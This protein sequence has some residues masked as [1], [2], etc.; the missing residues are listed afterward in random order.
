MGSPCLESSI[1]GTVDRGARSERVEAV[2]WKAARRMFPGCGGD[3][4]T[5][6][7]EDVGTGVGSICFPWI[8][9]KGDAACVGRFKG[10]GRTG[11]EDSGSKAGSKDGAGAGRFSPMI[12]E[13]ERAW[14][15]ED[16]DMG[17][18]V[19]RLS[20]MHCRQAKLPN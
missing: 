4:G 11:G 8:C 19:C 3:E 13:V 6:V 18:V 20:L 12:G 14:C 1:E 17:M 10:R 9:L 16:V 5:K 2:R 15:C 7:D